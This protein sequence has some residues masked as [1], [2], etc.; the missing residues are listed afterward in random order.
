M[1]FLLIS[2]T[3]LIATFRRVP[4]FVV[5]SV[6]T[7]GALIPKRD[8]KEEKIKSIK[9]NKSVK[10]NRADLIRGGVGNLALLPPE[11]NK[12][13]IAQRKESDDEVQE[14]EEEDLT[15]DPLSPPIKSTVSKSYRLPSPIDLLQSSPQR[16]AHQTDAILETQ[17]QIL[18][19]TL[20]NFGIEGKVTEIHPGPVITMYEFAPGPGIKVARIVSLAD[21]LAMALKAL[22]VRVV[23]LCPVSRRSELRF[24]TLAEKLWGLGIS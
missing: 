3:G 9:P 14:E 21:D 13:I 1:A 10:I 6:S 16:P 19:Q 2:P 24:P 18:T 20:L 23:A 7:V 5:M 8:P 4:Q 11:E 12:P 15:P 22:R 17:S